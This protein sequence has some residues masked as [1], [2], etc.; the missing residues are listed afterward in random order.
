MGFPTVTQPANADVYDWARSTDFLL[1]YPDGAS[2]QLRR[3]SLNANSDHDILAGI[4]AGALQSP[5]DLGS[6]TGS[7][8][9]LDESIGWTTPDL[10]AFINFFGN[11]GAGG[12]GGRSCSPAPFHHQMHHHHHHPPPP[13]IPRPT[14]SQS[15]GGSSLVT[16][17]TFESDSST[18]T[19]TT[20]TCTSSSTN[21][22]S[23]NANAAFVGERQLVEPVQ[24]QVPDAYHHHVQLGGG[25]SSPVQRKIER[26]PGSRN[27]KKFNGYRIKLVTKPVPTANSRKHKV[28]ELDLQGF[29]ERVAKAP[30]RTPMCTPA[31]PV[32]F[33]IVP[34][35]LAK[36]GGHGALKELSEEEKR[37]KALVRQ[38]GGGCFRCRM[39]NKKCHASHTGVCP[40]CKGSPH[41]CFRL[42]LD[43]CS[44][45]RSDTPIHIVPVSEQTKVW[46][47]DKVM[48][49]K[50]HC[51]PLNVSGFCEP[52][53]VD[54][55]KFVPQ[56]GDNLKK[57]PGG[58]NPEAFIEVEP[59]IAHSSDDMYKTLLSRMASYRQAFMIDLMSKGTSSVTISIMKL[60]DHLSKLRPNGIIHCALDIWVGAHLNATERSLCGEEL[61]GMPPDIIDDETSFLFGHVPIPPQLDNQLDNLIIKGMVSTATHILKTIWTKFKAKKKTDWLEL[62]VSVY[63]IL[64]T[65][66]FVLKTQQAYVEYLGSTFHRDK[67][68]AH[69]DHHRNLWSWSGNHLVDAFEYYHKKVDMPMGPLLRKENLGDAQT[70]TD[71]KLDNESFRLLR[72]IGENIQGTYIHPATQ[73]K[74]DVR[75]P[76]RTIS[77]QESPILVAARNLEP[78]ITK[79]PPAAK[80]G[81]EYETMWTSKIIFIR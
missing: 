48:V 22:S 32:Q 28:E 59:Y 19:A 63:I 20:T 70:Y 46:A 11:G 44:F 18:S 76:V 34:P 41:L 58:R 30:K 25:S 27:P 31:R 71:I 13:S 17:L 14:S 8:Y 29:E 45:F 75:Q 9:S 53:V 40:P 6:N 73:C 15:G 3:H 80:T 36:K 79:P 1:G 50:F 62:W 16:E 66:E 55:R 54:C 74:F 49:L 37:S 69:W 51:V 43:D 60:A 5:F 77:N 68:L 4:P 72:Q 64:N 47:T 52:L 57:S 61:L 33:S 67:I 81:V 35:E 26:G 7:F 12:G 23:A 56:P 21:A 10:D 2:P 42:D 38:F 65:V 78:K 39:L 24:V